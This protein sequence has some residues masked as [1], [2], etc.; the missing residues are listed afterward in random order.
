MRPQ[1]EGLGMIMPWACRHGIF[2]AKGPG[3][4][5][6]LERDDTEWA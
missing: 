5:I 6:S 3:S 4:R 1:I 2:R